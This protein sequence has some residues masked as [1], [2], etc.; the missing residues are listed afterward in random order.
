VSALPQLSLVQRP[1][2]LPQTA[3]AASSQ[4]TLALPPRADRITL[5]DQEQ[6][7]QAQQRYEIL[8][9]VLDFPENPRRYLSLSLADGRPV[10][11]LE[12]MI[13]YSAQLAGQSSRTV[14]RW[15]AQ[16]RAGGFA[17]LADRVRADKGVSRWFERHPQAR[18]FAAYLY[19]VERMSVS[20]VCEQLEYEAQ[21]LGIAQDLPSRETVRVFLSQSISPAMKT[22]ARQG[23][24]AYRERMSPYLKRGY[25][26]AFA[27][28]VWVGDHMIHD[29]EVSN[30]V[31]EEVPIGTPAR[32]RLSAFVDY[33]SRKAW[34]TWACEGSS[35]SIAATL[36]RGILEVGPPEHIY[37]D[38]GKDYRKVAKGAQRGSDAFLDE[39]SLSPAAWWNDEYAAIEKTGILARLGITVTHCIP[40]HPQSKHVERFFR[41]L[42]E[43]FDAAHATY[44][45][46]SPATRPAAT[47][48]A[49]M[50]HRWLLKRGRAGESNHPL[51]SQVILGCL[52]WIEHYN[53]SPHSGEGMDGRTPNQVF[54]S[55]LNPNQK[56]SPEPEKLALL[57]MDYTRRQVRECAVTI[58]KRRY[59]PRPEDRMAW[60]AM[61]EANSTEILVAYN[62]TDPEY[63][64]ALDQD[65]R[66]L[67]WLEAEDLLA[68]APW[69]SETNKKIGQSMEIRRGLE[70]ATKQSLRLI[71]SAARAGGARS[72]QEMLYDRLQLTDAVETVI[73]QRKLHTSSPD[74]PQNTLAP[75][76]AADR[77]AERLRRNQ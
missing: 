65:G 38:N 60:A 62:A 50:K 68:F 29:V 16:Y 3:T 34:G 18:V 66:F 46:G 11:S 70:K 48:E 41:T 19:L 69:D 61:H 43:R 45:S 2:A 54:E 73:T 20:F 1:S 35:R 26:D 64:A 25:V 74:E 10:S 17:A 21:Q 76:Q 33:R 49:M 47:G 31:F 5:A 57:L 23:E 28:Q 58:A 59:T 56:P 37:V 12:R 6:Q 13:E 32:L 63:V 67:A 52:S 75:G 27:N 8:L 4:L 40:R 14:K 51:A 36:L 53:N 71:A 39:S 24:R 30:D 44:T 22:Y 7:K 15:L 9:P 42:H 77:L 55:E 72:A